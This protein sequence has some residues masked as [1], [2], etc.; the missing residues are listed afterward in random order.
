MDFELFAPAAKSINLKVRNRSRLR[1]VGTPLRL[2]K[3]QTRLLFL[4]GGIGISTIGHAAA[5]ANGPINS[6]TL[7][8]VARVGTLFANI[9]AIGQRDA[10][11]LP[12]AGSELRRGA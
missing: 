8:L 9:T 12:P 7:T 2:K 10:D 5:E 6:Q 4:A 11:N 3:I 1:R